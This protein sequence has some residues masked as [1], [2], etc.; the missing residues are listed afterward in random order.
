[1]DFPNVVIKGSE[2][3]LPFQSTLK[4]EKFG[5]MILK[6]TE[7]QMVLFNIYD[8][9]LKT[10]SS[11]TAFSR[12]I[13]ILRA[14]HVSP[15]RTKALLRPDKNTITQPHHVWPTL[16]DEDWIKVE[17]QLKD[18]IL[19]DYG[20]K[21]N[22][23]VASLTQSEVRDIILGMQI[24]PPSLQRQQVAEVE[25]AAR[26]QSQLTAVT[27]KTTN[28]HGDAMAI[29]TTSQYEQQSFNTRTDWRIRAISASNLHLR[30][31]HIY[32]SSEDI[33]ESGF[34]YVFP[35]NILS[36]FITISDLRTQIGGY[37]YGVSPADNPQVKEVRCIVMVPQVGNH[38]QVTMP[39]K[40]PDATMAGFEYLEGLEPLG[41]VHTQPTELPQLSPLDVFT[42]AGI[43]ADN[44]SWDGEKAIILTCSFTPGSCSLTAYKLTPQGFEWGKANR[45]VGLAAQGYAPAFYERVQMLLSDRFLGSF[46][47]P[48]DEIW[49]YNF[50]GVKHS[51]G[52]DYNLMAGVPKEFYH[53]SFRPSHFLTFTSMEEAEEATNAEVDFDDV[54]S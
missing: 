16:T 22:I 54:F 8:D 41:W 25:K 28:V 32:V 44:Q 24:Q 42:H 5:D 20:K 21:N 23:N 35:K 34:T 4:I 40:I 48:E 37:I 31:N 43:M 14:L 6:A 15:D 53:E 36:K 52:M 2:L 51:V 17:V 45:D 1:L 13:L 27:T 10:I 26:E 29:T 47:V 12:L 3:Q 9:W 7:P 39:R 50:M 33:S 49:N 38:Q 18:L 30:T 11:Y 46:L 19:A